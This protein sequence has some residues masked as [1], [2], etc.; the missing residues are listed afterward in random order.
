M[1]TTL[2]IPISQG[3]VDYW[4]VLCSKA[5]EVVQGMDYNKVGYEMRDNA[6]GVTLFFYEVVCKED[7]P[8]EYFKD[9]VYPSFVR[10]LNYK[11]LDPGSGQRL[12]VSLYYEERFYLI[13]GPGFIEAFCEIEGIDRLTYHSYVLQWLSEASL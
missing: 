4:K 8:W 6:E 3:P 9:R 11:S 5:F 1:K 7:R 2:P 12:I 10:Y 13:R